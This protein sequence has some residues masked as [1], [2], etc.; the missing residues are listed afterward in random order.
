MVDFLRDMKGQHILFYSFIM[1]MFFQVN[2]GFF[3]WLRKITA[4]C[5]AKRIY[6]KV[7]SHNDIFI[8]FLYYIS[9]LNGCSLTSIILYVYFLYFYFINFAK[10]N[11]TYNVTKLK[12]GVGRDTATAEANY[13][14]RKYCLMLYIGVLSDMLTTSLGVYFQQRITTAII[15]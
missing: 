5:N 4:E 10:E 14:R 2:E 9:I 15:W 6:F 8:I 7:R 11:K 13:S 1:V 12:K 3:K